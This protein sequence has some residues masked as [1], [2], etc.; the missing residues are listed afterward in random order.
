MVKLRN[1]FLYFLFLLSSLWINFVFAEVQQSSELPDDLIVKPKIGTEDYNK[2]LSV[3][4]EVPD[5]KFGKVKSHDNYTNSSV[6]QKTI[7]DIDNYGINNSTPYKIS[8]YKQNDIKLKIDDDRN[9]SSGNKFYMMFQLNAILPN[10][11]ILKEPGY[12]GIELP[13]LPPPYAPA[14]NFLPNGTR[15][16]TYSILSVKNIIVYPYIAFGFKTNDVF[17]FEIS[18]MTTKIKLQ[19]NKN[20]T[21]LNVAYVNGYDSK[22]RFI[23]MDFKQQIYLLNSYVDL[24]L[25][26]MCLYFGIGLGVVNN[27][28]NKFNMNIEDSNNKYTLSGL[29]DKKATY[30]RATMVSIGF[31]SKIYDNTFVDMSI[32]KMSLGRVTTL[33]DY[34]LTQTNKITSASISDIITMNSLEMKNNPYVVSIGIRRE[35]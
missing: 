29:I 18:R 26:R 31:Y 11:F 6:K 12:F 8:D 5:T 3:L 20:D 1:S 24:K 4:E 34:R 21:G 16:G 25:K 32:K 33:K 14:Y 13:Q 2:K 23:E 35:F 30:K 17:R 9:V 27:Q 15:I 22:T 28:L 10:D 7:Y 19:N